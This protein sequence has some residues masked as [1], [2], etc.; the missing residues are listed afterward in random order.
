M[1]YIIKN[2]ITN[3]GQIIQQNFFLKLNKLLNELD[4]NG[5]GYKK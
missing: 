5:I 1:K 4:L 3:F 2:I